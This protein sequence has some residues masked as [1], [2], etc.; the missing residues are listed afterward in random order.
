MPA[1]FAILGNVVAAQPRSAKSAMAA[2]TIAS[3]VAAACRARSGEWYRDGDLLF[4]AMR[5]EHRR[6]P[7][8]PD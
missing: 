3:R 4:V 5:A 6:L 8:L 2:A 7:V 1:L